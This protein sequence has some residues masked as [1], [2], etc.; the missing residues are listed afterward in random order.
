MIRVSRCG[1]T[2]DD[3]LTSGRIPD[4]VVSSFDQLVRDILARPG[5]WRLLTNRLSQII[6]DDAEQYCGPVETH[7]QLAFRRFQRQLRP[8]N[9][10]TTAA[11]RARILLL[12][13]E[14]MHEMT[15]WAR[16]VFSLTRPRSLNFGEHIRA[17]VAGEAEWSFDASDTEGAAAA[18]A[19]AT[20][21][22]HSVPNRQKERKKQL[23]EVRLGRHQLFYDLRD[24]RMADDTPLPLPRLIEHCELCGVPWTLRTCGDGRVG[25]DFKLLGLDQPPR[26]YTADLLNACVVILEGAYSAV[27]RERRNV[28]RAGAHY[29]RMELSSSTGERDALKSVEIAIISAVDSIEMTSFLQVDRAHPA[30]AL[31]NELPR[32]VVRI[33]TDLVRRQHLHAELIGRPV[34]VA[35]ILDVF[36]AE[37][38]PMLH[39][40]IASGGLRLDEFDDIPVSDPPRLETRVTLHLTDRSATGAATASIA[41]IPDLRHVAAT[42][43]HV[44]DRTSLAQVSHADRGVA[45]FVWYPH[46]IAELEGARWLHVTAT[47]VTGAADEMQPASS[48]S[49]P[50]P[51]ASELLIEPWLDRAISV[52]KRRVFMKE[53]PQDIEKEEVGFG[54]QTVD[55]RFGRFTIESEHLGTH[56]VDPDSGRT[57]ERRRRNQKRPTTLPQFQT[58][59]MQLRFVTTDNEPALT[60]RAARIISAA[61]R[62]AL[63]S[64]IR[65]SEAEVAVALCI[66]RNPEVDPSSLTPWNEWDIMNEEDCIAIFD[67]H[68]EGGGGTRSIRRDGL[69]PLLELVRLI[70]G[71]VL[72]YDRLLELF[73]EL[74]AAAQQTMDE[75]PD[76]IHEPAGDEPIPSLLQ[77]T[78]E[79]EPAEPGTTDPPVPATLA[80]IQLTSA[81]PA[82]P[83][84]IPAYN[85]PQEEE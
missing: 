60:Y 37:V 48:D 22:A 23:D 79:T 53:H 46:R 51:T 31:V 72:D 12:G 55:V 78:S 76:P 32:P 77:P 47:P 35:D 39:Q 7:V 80:R 34:E 20:A 49:S 21:S 4:V 82:S 36:G 42:L 52:P 68:S 2:M 14:S 26:H 44:R 84:E 28:G 38:A 74:P 70:V 56:F 10:Q 33:P 41:H 25:L 69:R 58:E 11:Y 59:A 1:D 65:N 30:T 61:L 17:A 83:I 45:E 73:D 40:L 66:S 18:V 43:I 62:V 13:C 75:E 5:D 15:V 57:I 67:I 27:A 19:A 3:P 81:R 16:S 29:E 85:D 9:E 71:R 64:F 54:T 6:I 50:A 24:F 8:G 63:R